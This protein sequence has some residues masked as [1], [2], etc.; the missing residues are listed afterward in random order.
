MDLCPVPT[1]TPGST[2]I[3]ANWAR[4]ACT[5]PMRAACRSTGSGTKPCVPSMAPGLDGPLL[6]AHVGPEQLRLGHLLS[7][8]AL[9]DQDGL[10]QRL[11][12]RETG[13]EERDPTR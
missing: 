11:S 7:R 2:P 1:F 8:A 10:R 3:P 6:I 5:H 9:G 12:G 13:H 4:M